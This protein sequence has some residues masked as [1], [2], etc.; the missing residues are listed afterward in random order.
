MNNFRVLCD[1]TNNSQEDKENNKLN[2]D[3]FVIPVNLKRYS[4]AELQMLYGRNHEVW[5]IN[6]AIKYLGKQILATGA[7]EV[8]FDDTFKEQLE[9]VLRILK[10]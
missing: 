8:V 7:K 4:I 3:V 5:Q 2:V 6:K 1:E 10:P 9:E